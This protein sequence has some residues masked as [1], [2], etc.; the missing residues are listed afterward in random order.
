MVRLTNYSNYKYF[1]A[2]NSII[3]YKG[4]FNE[5]FKRVKVMSVM[6]IDLM[7]SNTCVY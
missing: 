5:V 6:Y 1:T 7:S 2:V 4:V 3:L